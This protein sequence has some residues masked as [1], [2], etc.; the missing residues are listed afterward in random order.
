MNK[1][2][3]LSDLKKGKVIVLVAPSGSGKTTIAKRLLKE[4]DNLTFSISATTRHPR[5]GEVDGKDYYFL[6][7]ETFQKN[8]NQGNFLEWEEFYN[9]KRYGSLRSEVEKQL[10]S[11]YNILFDIEVKGALNIRKYFGKDCL[12]IFIK[13][14]SL[15]VLKNR[16]I[17]RNS[18][19][20]DSL[21]ERLERAE[22]ELKQ[23]KKFDI[24]IIND[25]LE[26][27]Y[28]QIKEIVESFIKKS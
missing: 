8:I 18:E 10:N 28:S 25:D 27:A 20:K 26:K 11:G 22:M 17:K 16:L 23:E 9:G 7:P 19:T 21:N 14:P 13:P 3:I 4:I 12:T 6:T 2:K 15:E 5:S 1:S 24:V